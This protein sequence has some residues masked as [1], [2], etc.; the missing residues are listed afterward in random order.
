MG[1]HG[2][3][4]AAARLRLRLLSAE[5]SETSESRDSA[6]GWARRTEPKTDRS[7]GKLFS[8]YIMQLGRTPHSTRPP[9]PAAALLLLGGL[10]WQSGGMV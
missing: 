1:Q 5:T 2:Q 6:A 10:R 8:S 9:D 7:D 4:A 3:R